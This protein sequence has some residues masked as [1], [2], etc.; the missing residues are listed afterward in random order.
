[1]VLALFSLSCLDPGRHMA[2]PWGP[3]LL[4]QKRARRFAKRTTTLPS[5]S[6]SSKRR[7]LTS[8]IIPRNVP[9]AWSGLRAN[10]RELK[11]FDTALSFTFPLVGVASTTAA[12]GGVALIP[13]GITQSQ[14]IGRE[15]VIKSIQLRANL[16]LD[17]GA[18][19]DVS[20]GTFL[21]L[22]LDTQANGAY[23]TAANIFTG[24]S[25]WLSFLNL[26]NSRRFRVLKAWHHQYDPGAG[27]SGAYNFVSHQLDF[28]M[29]CNIRMEY[30]AA[31]GAITEIRSNNLLLC[32]GGTNDG[33]VTL[34]GACR[35][36]FTG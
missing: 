7:K 13:Q 12:T 2:S 9:S 4:A 21:Y 31:A 25:F 29:K 1:M 16:S 26:S 30:D 11:F 33:L 24:T 23:P 18:S 32:R 28:F 27:V 36:R 8:A 22:I 19:V 3:L 20:S 17:P 35:L 15:C 6:S 5:S 34:D 14:R 10:P